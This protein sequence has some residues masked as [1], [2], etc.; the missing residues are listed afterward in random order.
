MYMA[1]APRVFA[2]VCLF[3]AVA[4][5]A[6][7]PVDLEQLFRDLE[8]ENS[9]TQAEAAEMLA[10]MAEEIDEAAPQFER[11]LKSESTE[12]RLA[13]VRAL[14]ATQGESAT[15]L[16]LLV[17]ALDD[18]SPENRETAA[19]LIGRL[20]PRAASATES[21]SKALKDENADVCIEAANAL[22]AIGPRAK[23]AV[24]ELVAALEDHRK[25]SVFTSLGSFSVSDAAGLALKQIGPG[26]ISA[27]TPHLKH[28]NVDVRIKAMW[29]LAAGGEGS[30]PHFP[31]LMESLKA[32]DSRVRQAA[33]EI[34]GALR[35]AP[36]KSIPALADR[37]KDENQS[38]RFHAAGSLAKYGRQAE[39]VI[40]QLIAA[41]KDEHPGVR[42]RAADALGAIGP[43]AKTATAHLERLR[44]DREIYAYPHAIIN[45]VGPHAVQAIKRIQHESKGTPE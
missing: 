33:V 3:S 27:I 1:T 15:H 29:V 24:P 45:E 2:I 26:A 44:E 37:L 21:L 9:A 12:V 40:P 38:V 8:S 32:D 18:K 16:P 11:L 20:G 6:W 36:A 41:L 22:G 7:E 10:K 28:E 17:A 39:S 14:W 13:G 19:A 25:S 31:L 43:A 35:I 23:G 4:A 30:L 34:F 5:Y 42:A